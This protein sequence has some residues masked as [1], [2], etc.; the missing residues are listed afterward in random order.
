MKDS[1]GGNNMRLSKLWIV[2]STCG[3]VRIHVA[4]RVVG[5][6]DQ[7]F[8]VRGSQMIMIIQHGAAV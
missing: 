3:Q 4:G 5:S 7:D 6:N 2:M 1:F 8:G